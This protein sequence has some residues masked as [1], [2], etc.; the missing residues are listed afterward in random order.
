MGQKAVLI[1]RQ[2]IPHPTD[3]HVVPMHCIACMCGGIA[4]TSP[5]WDMGEAHYDTSYHHKLAISGIPHTVHNW[6][7]PSFTP[8]TQTANGVIDGQHPTAQPP[9]D[10]WPIKWT[11]CCHGNKAYD[12]T[13]SSPVI[14]TFVYHTIHPLVQFCHGSRYYGL[15]VLSPVMRIFAHYTLQGLQWSFCTAWEI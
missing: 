15:P 9:G 8:K 6:S 14:R 1:F 4:N 12:T 5:T 11:I 10:S 2:H 13:V 7:L 3:L